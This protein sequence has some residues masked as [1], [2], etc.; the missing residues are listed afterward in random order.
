MTWGWGIGIAGPGIGGFWIKGP[1]ILYLWTIWTAGG[2]GRYTFLGI[3]SKTVL[4]IG[5]CCCTTG[6][7]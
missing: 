2:L 6:L 3:L 7:L 4:T 1:Y 5:G